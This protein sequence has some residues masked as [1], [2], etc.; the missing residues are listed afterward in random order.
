MTLLLPK[1]PSPEDGDLSFGII[2]AVDFDS[3]RAEAQA[4]ISIQMGD[5]DAEIE[6][7]PI[8]GTFFIKE[9]E[10]EYLTEIINEFHKRFGGI[11]TNE[12]E[13]KELLVALPE[14]V[15]QNEGYQNAQRNSDEQNSRIECEDALKASVLD[16]MTVNMEFYRNYNSNP[17]FRRF[18]SDYVFS[19]TY[20][21]IAPPPDAHPQV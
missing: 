17:E 13:A 11:W 20:R 19:Q 4:M 6:P 15:A 18:L 5:A 21:P 12:D 9:P 8:G 1:L 10:M 16:M 3:Y 14:R 2:E 7:I